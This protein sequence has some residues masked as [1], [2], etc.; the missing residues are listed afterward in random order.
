[1][2]IN[3]VSRLSLTVVEHLY[4]RGHQSLA[5]DQLEYA[6]V[7]ANRQ[8]RS[9]ALA[10]EQNAPDISRV[11]RRNSALFDGLKHPPTYAIGE[12]VW[13]YNTAAT[14]RQGAKAGTNA[15][16]F[17]VKLSLN[18]TEPLKRFVLTLPLRHA[19]RFHTLLHQ[20]HPSRRHP[21]LVQGPLSSRV[22]RQDL[23]P[24][25]NGRPL[26]RPLRGRPRTSE[27]SSSLLGTRRISERSATRSVFK[28]VKVEPS[29]GNFA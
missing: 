21:L 14:I 19:P 11:E 10:C 13:I 3:C 26:R 15:K 2:H 7:A 4:A 1:M 29:A 5:R 12:W 25:H 24:Y 17:K 18:W 22:T 6:D 20:Y 16:V 9:I 28:L 8:R 27:S 23:R